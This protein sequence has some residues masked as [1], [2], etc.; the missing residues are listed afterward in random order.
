MLTNCLFGCAKD[1]EKE[2]VKAKEEDFFNEYMM[3]S[4]ERCY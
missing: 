2:T 4:C 1:E 3:V